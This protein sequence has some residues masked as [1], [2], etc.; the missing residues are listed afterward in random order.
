ML[1]TL[2]Y[3]SRKLSPVLKMIGFVSS[4][5]VL[6]FI[7]ST[8]GDERVKMELV[9][10]FDPLPVSSYDETSFGF[11]TIKKTLLDQFPQVSVAP[12]KKRNRRECVKR[13]WY[14]FDLPTVMLG[15][16]GDP[17]FGMGF[18]GNMFTFL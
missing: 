16:G 7:Q 15:K 3:S 1:A 9:N 4:C 13:E 18:S 12:G 17:A 5:Q 6:E 8:V 10:G 11:Q 14:L 2:K